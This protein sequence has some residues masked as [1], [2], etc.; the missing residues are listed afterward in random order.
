MTKGTEL[1]FTIGLSCYRLIDNC[2]PSMKAEDIYD[3][4][5]EGKPILH[6]TVIQLFVE[7]D[8][9]INGQGV[10]FVDSLRTEEKSES[11]QVKTLL[12]SRPPIQVNE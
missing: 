3:C 9:K 11:I 7:R 5:V 10:S 12:I 4:T 2:I 8:L 1:E 6:D